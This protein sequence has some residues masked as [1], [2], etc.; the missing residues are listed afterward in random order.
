MEAGANDL[1]TD[2]YIMKQ[3]SKYGISDFQLDFHYS[4]FWADPERQFR[5]KKWEN[6]NSSALIQQ[7]ENYT[8]SQLVQIYDEL[9][10]LPSSVQIGNEITKGLLW[11]RSNIEKSKSDINLSSKYVEAGIKGLKKAQEYANQKGYKKNMEVVLH[12][13]SPI[14]NKTKKAVNKYFS[15]EFVKE[16][17]DIIGLTWYPFWNGRF[18]Y[19]AS[20]FLSFWKKLNKKIYIKEYSLPYSFSQSEYTGDL[21]MKYGYEKAP[22]TSSG[23]AAM[24]NAFLMSLSQ[25]FYNQETGF[26]YW[27]L[28]W[29]NTGKS[30]WSSEVGL[31][32]LNNYSSNWTNNYKPGF[33]WSNQ[34]LFDTNGI[35]LPQMKVL[36]NFERIASYNPVVHNI[37]NWINLDIENFN[38]NNEDQFFKI[39]KLL[40]NDTLFKKVDISKE[41]YLDVDGSYSTELNYYKNSWKKICHKM[42]WKHILKMLILELCEEVLIFQILRLIMIV[43]LLISMLMMIHFITKGQSKLLL[44]KWIISQIHPMFLI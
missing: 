17:V 20:S 14:S 26:Y 30:S 29:L 2:I 28:G 3:A 27:E 8:Y 4:D 35:M 15:N 23:Q 12:V 1:D 24:M 18:D 36:K 11:D 44:K 22:F 39:Q 13:E 34:G 16:N 38:K 43:I 6:L 42:I 37:S 19:L 7:V 9:N 21:N 10:F 40:W 5:P 25:S 33:T 41:M 31:Q 32:Y